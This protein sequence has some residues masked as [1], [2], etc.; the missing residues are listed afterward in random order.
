[1]GLLAFCPS[2]ER[3]GLKIGFPEYLTQSANADLGVK[4]KIKTKA[5]KKRS[6][7]K[8]LN[9]KLRAG[10]CLTLFY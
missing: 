9:Q 8:S 1:M 2:Q 10:I 5:E 3:D 7:N 6:L 4:R